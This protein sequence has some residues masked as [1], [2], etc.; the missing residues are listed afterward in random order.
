MMKTLFLSIEINLKTWLWEMFWLS[1]HQ[2]H[3]SG[4]D[5]SLLDLTDPSFPSVYS[6]HHPVFS[7]FSH[8]LTSPA[9]SFWL[10]TSQ[11]PK[12]LC[13]LHSRHFLISPPFFISLLFSSFVKYHLRRSR[14]IFPAEA[15]HRSFSLPS[16]IYFLLIS[17]SIS[18]FPQHHRICI[19]LTEIQTADLQLYS[20]WGAGTASY[21]WC[22]YWFQTYEF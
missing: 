2:K 3:V 15:P 22:V 17:S 5:S 19:L 21:F 8:L 7:S 9:L 18:S 12:V 10:S 6:S 16:F 20:E 14:L 13:C 11:I 4:L 1:F